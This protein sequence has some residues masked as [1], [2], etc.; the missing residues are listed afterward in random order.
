MRMGLGLGEKM[1]WGQG[2]GWVRFGFE[3]GGGGSVGEGVGLKS[4]DGPGDRVVGEM[5]LGMGLDLEHEFMD[6]EQCREWGLGTG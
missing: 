1:D 2:R 6:L 5:E 3:D 4:R